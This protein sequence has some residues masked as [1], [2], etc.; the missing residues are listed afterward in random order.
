M[1]DAFGKKEI[2]KV[3]EFAQISKILTKLELIQIYVNNL[4]AFPFPLQLVSLVKE[5]SLNSSIQI[6]IAIHDYF[7][8]CPSFN[9]L[10]NAGKFCNLPAVSVCQNCLPNLKSPFVNFS[11]INDIIKWR[12][13][14]NNLFESN[15]EIHCFSKS[16]EE[17]FL[18]CFPE[19]GSKIKVL[20]HDVPELSQYKPET[21]Q[22]PFINIG[23]IGQINFNKG[24]EIINSIYSLIVEK[25]LPI[26]I[27]VIGSIIGDFKE[28]YLAQ[29][30]SYNVS[31][32]PDLVEKYA[33]DF[34]FM[35]SIW[36]ETF[37]YVAHEIKSMGLPM[38]TFDLGAQADLAKS[39]EK[40][41]VIELGDPEDIINQLLAF[42]Q[43]LKKF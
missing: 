1:V 36:P 28:P 12:K 22:F 14:W 40:G 18:K 35:P 13:E 34:A 6:T 37:S 9:L 41:F 24:L 10:N 19:A 27:T 42:Y 2:E 4:V 3:S 11:G 26:R 15:C 5:I 21:N 7:P 39:Y 17:L 33:I 16:S 25:N 29:T 23:V 8:L 30:G 20:P 31:E 32:L 43:N 38:V